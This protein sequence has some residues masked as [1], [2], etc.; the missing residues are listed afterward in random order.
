[1]TLLPA[2]CPFKTCPCVRSKRPCIC[3]GVSGIALLESQQ[4]RVERWLCVRNTMSILADARRL[5]PGTA[6][7]HT[8]WECNFCHGATM[9]NPDLSSWC[10]TLKHS[11]DSHH[12]F[13]SRETP[14]ECQFAFVSTGRRAVGVP[15]LRWH[16]Y[17][18]P[19]FTPSYSFTSTMSVSRWAKCWVSE[20]NSACSFS[21]TGSW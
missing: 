8:F 7:C 10:P 6:L 3:F 19:T 14:S 15:T 17:G 4:Q 21:R 12:G 9:W 20:C 13:Q 1:M 11:L 18:R 2:V 5:Q 16:R